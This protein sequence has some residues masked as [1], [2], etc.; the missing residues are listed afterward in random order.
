MDIQVLPSVS[1]M[2]YFWFHPNVC[3][4]ACKVTR[5]STNIPAVESPYA[6]G[7]LLDPLPTRERMA[8][9]KVTSGK[10]TMNTSGSTASH[11]L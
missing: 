6:G 4:S 8:D 1:G 9:S 3:D 2:G 10:L 11:C 7:V 5:D